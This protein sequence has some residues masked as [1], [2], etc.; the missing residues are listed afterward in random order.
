M[1]NLLTEAEQ[2]H[3][4]IALATVIETWGA[5]P[6]GVGA[7][8]AFTSTGKLSGS[9]SGGCVETSVIETGQAVL[10]SG[11]P[12]LLHFGVAD[13]TAWSVGLSCGGT[14]DVFVEPL[15]RV[16]HDCL[17]TFERSDPPAATVTV[18]KGPVELLGKKLL[19]QDRA[20]VQGGLGAELDQAAVDAAGA[21]LREARS[22][23]ATLPATPAR[24]EPIEVFIE[25]LAAPPTL[26]A[27]GGVHIAIALTA[28]AKTLGYRTIVIDPR[29]VFGSSDRFPHVDQLIQAWPDAAFRQVSLSD[30]TAVAM[31][32]HDPK[33]DEQALTA[34]LNSPAYYIGALGSSVT[35]AKRRQRL[36]EAGL[37]EAQVDRIHA[38]IGIDIGART[39]EEIAL[40]VMAEIVAARPRQKSRRAAA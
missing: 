4:P 6:R 21:V 19:L 27:V 3:E 25:V 40:S 17:A 20:V 28:I 14:I 35:Q 15:D 8:M 12:Q 36:L 38:P 2:W 1:T 24:R 11:L 16:T 7:K 30:T 9:V 37:S 26:I 10:A 18:V 33:I 32:T 34:V 29:R 23:R 13:E 5:A 39:P 31:L 22:R